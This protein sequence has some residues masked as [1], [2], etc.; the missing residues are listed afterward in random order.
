LLIFF[1][2]NNAIIFDIFNEPYPNGNT[3]DATAAWSCWKSGTDCTGTNYG[4]AGM[5]ELVNAVRSTG[6]THILMLGGIAYS[7]SLT[8]WLTYAPNDTIQQLAASWHSYNFNYCNNQNC[9]QQYILPVSDKVPVI[10]GEMGENNCAHD[11][12]DSLM[13]WADSHGLSYLGWTWNTWD[14]STGPA[15]I[16][17]YDGTPTNFGVGIRN[18]YTAGF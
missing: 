13:N 1:K 11:Y 2:G 16:S 15:L 9:W 10:I 6:A 12:V 8:Q 3:F 7:N 17:N 5:Q 14:C 18:H 4:V